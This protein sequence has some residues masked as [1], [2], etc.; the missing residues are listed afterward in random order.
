MGLAASQARLLFITARQNDVSARMQK[1]SSANMVLAR[2]EDDVMTEYNRRLNA[3]IRQPV[4]ELALGYEY[5]MGAGAYK[6]NTINLVTDAKTGQVVLNSR[7]LQALGL[8]TDSGNGDTFKNKYPDVA[9]FKAALEPTME[10]AAAELTAT[11]KTAEAEAGDWSEAATEFI[12]KYGEYPALKKR[13][14]LAD[15]LRDMGGNYASLNVSQTLQSPGDPND[16]SNWMKNRSQGIINDIARALGINADGMYKSISGYVDTLVAMASSNDNYVS[17]GDHGSA[18]GM[19]NAANE[20]GKSNLAVHS[21]ENGSTW[22]HS[23]DTWR[24]NES[25]LVRRIIEKVSE[26]FANGTFSTTNAST[27]MAGTTSLNNNQDDLLF[28]YNSFGYSE[29]EYKRLLQR[30][31]DNGNYDNLTFTQAVNIVKSKNPVDPENNYNKGSQ[32]YFETLYNALAEHGWTLLV[33]ED[34]SSKF[35]KSM[36]DGDYLVGNINVMYTGLYEE[37]DDEKTQATA[38]TYYN[39]E[40]KKI[41]RKEKMLDNELTKLNTEYSALTNDFNSVK[42]ILDA[43]IQKSFTYCQT[44]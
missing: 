27:S 31:I 16:V 32:G 22:H 23:G 3:K 18:G 14:N 28:K 37:V 44:G 8:P 38:E 5:L 20:K 39:Q 34:D 10:T 29:T 9:S 33:D 26:S 40:M 21:H 2:D 25:E 24:V 36:E 41:Q 7:I 4:D 42:A 35:R 17:A 43:N 13:I 6:T 19:N 15:M 30:A 1:I 12:A 11:K